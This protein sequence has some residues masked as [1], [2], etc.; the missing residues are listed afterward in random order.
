MSPSPSFDHM[1]IPSSPDVPTGSPQLPK[2]PSP[3]SAKV[4]T[5]KKERRQTSITPRRFGKFFDNKAA[6][7]SMSSP[8]GRA[9]KRLVNN[10]QETQSSPLK[11]Y[12]NVELQGQENEELISTPREFKRR[13]TNHCDLSADDDCFFKD[14]VKIHHGQSHCNS[15]KIASSNSTSQLIVEE[16]EEEVEEDGPIEASLPKEPIERIVPFENCGMSARIL[17]LS[18]GTSRSRRAN[19]AYPVNDWR[20]ETASFYSRP[21]DVSHTVSLMGGRDSIPFCNAGLNTNSLVAI[22]DDEGRIRLVESEKN[23]QPS[24]S[25]VHLGWQIHKNAIIDL[26]LSDDDA[27][28]ATASGDL[29]AK[30]SDMTTQ[31]PIS[32]LAN[33]SATLKQVRFQPGANNKN[34]LATSGRDG[35]VQIWDLRCKGSDG[36]IMEMQKL[37]GENIPR[38]GNVKG[39]LN[40][41]HGSHFHEPKPAAGFRSLSGPRKGRAGDI[42]VTSIHFLPPGQEHLLLTGSESN[43]I[44][45]LWDIRNCSNRRKSSRPVACTKQ[46]PSHVSNRPF[47]ITS[48]SMSHDG[49]R[50]YSVCKDN[51]VY[52]YSTSHLILGHASELE[53]GN[54]K[55]TSQRA[56]QEGSG[57]LYGF[58]HPS[59]HVAN[60]YIKSAIRKPVN[61]NSEL[62][63]VGSNDGTPILFPTDERYLGTKANTSIPSEDVTQHSRTLSPN[64]LSRPG[65]LSSA[66]WGSKKDT[67]VEDSI[68]IYTHGTA[69]IRGHGREVS[70]LSWTNNGELICADDDWNVRCWREGRDARDLRMGGETGGRRWGCGWADIRKDYD[71]EDE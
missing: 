56:V 44:V 40:A 14:P 19:L 36:P 31:Q 63:A 66:I 9:L 33:H 62:L 42:S 8:S 27:L 46:V 4:R 37:P 60:F 12:N 1:E 71:D 29:S 41:H 35:S 58:R 32:I 2:L 30:V 45:K 55:G 7:V 67:L 34:V 69:L 52:A 20:D 49:S 47:G 28:V 51:V 16:V 65:E 54:G 3:I 15:S 39:I 57:P 21:E 68:P 10:H 24:F 53:S 43:S 18:L 11:P 5:P 17:Q 25:S 64:S 13:K 59:F 38:C 70:S 61:G 22:G 6:T 50:F 23:G 26:S 48:L